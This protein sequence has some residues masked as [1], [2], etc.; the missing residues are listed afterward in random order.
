MIQRDERA[1]EAVVEAVATAEGVDRDSLP[2][3]GANLDPDALDDL[4]ASRTPSPVAGLVFTRTDEISNDLE[5]QFRY[6][7]YHVTV[8]ENYVLLE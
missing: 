4:F 5:V 2:A 7:G 1:T 3:L 6:A 8:T